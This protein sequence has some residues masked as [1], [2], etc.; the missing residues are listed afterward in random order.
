MNQL[1]PILLAYTFPA[2]AAPALPLADDFRRPP[3]TA[4]PG[5]YW[6]FMDGNLD[7][8]EMIR[9]LDAMKAAG[10]GH[11]IHLEVNV[12][13]PRG[14]VTSLSEQWFEIF[15]HAARHA[16]KIGIG[17]TIG[18]G[19][20]WT[21]SGGPWIS[22]AESMQHLVF[23]ETTIKG[24]VSFNGKLPIAP[25]RDKWWKM[26][27]CD[28]YEDVTVHA[29]PACKPTIQDAEWKAFY[30]RGHY[31]ANEAPAVLPAPSRHADTPAREKID[32]GRIIDLTGKLA[33]DGTLTLLAITPSQGKGPQNLLVTPDGRWLLCA[34]MPGGNVAVFRIDSATGS[35]TPHGQP[36]EMP[37][38]SCIRWVP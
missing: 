23:S 21:G 20:G 24:P 15:G 13:V 32:P 28:F 16:E 36:V 7:R 12:N 17:M 34:N 22:E 10:L 9:D 19:P 35:L 30:A 18:T 25:Q 33:A 8:E 26:L 4:R 11:V 2:I 14:P 27:P 37:M 1:L 6:Y 29:F 3:D 38:P 5:V 31:S